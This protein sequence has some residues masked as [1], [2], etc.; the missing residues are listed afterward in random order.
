M[1]ASPVPTTSRHPRETDDV[2]VPATLRKSL[3]N[4]HIQLIAL[5]GAIGT[6]LFYGSSESI[7]LAGPSILLAYLV[8][9]LAIF[10]IVRA[11]SEMSVED[12]KAGAFSY[13]AT[14]YWSKRAGFVSGWNY[15]FN[16]ILVSMVE[17]SVVGSFVNYWFPN[18]PQWVSAA[19]FLVVIAA[20][21][22][23]G[24]SKFG[25]FEFW[26]A[27]IK[28]VAV[29][30]MIL[31]GLAVLVANLP[32]ASGI[33]AS[34]AN[35]FAI[36][37]GFF[38]HGLMQ[39][40][41]DGQWTGLLMALCVVM[42]SFGGTELIGITAGETENPRTTIPRATNGI[43]WRILVFYIGALGVIMAVVPWNTIDGKSS[44]FVQIFDS[45]GV[46]AAAGILNF[47]CL[48]AVMSVYNSGL[49]ANSRMLYSLAKQG[50][51]PAYLGK[52]NSRGVP[53]AGVITSAIITALAVV[54]V[55]LWPEFAFNYLMSIATIAGVINWSMIMITEVHFRKV[56]AAGDGPAELAGLQGK[57]AL[58]AIHFKLPFARVMPYI[59]LAFLALVVVLMCFSPS[60]RVAVVA[61]VIWLAILLAAYQI[62]QVRK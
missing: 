41:A 11:L 45:V 42:F 53:V 51:A 1:A 46:H 20:A 58:D 30:A 50:N 33:K 61:G 8:G 35:W 55:F 54:V 22:L 60:Y 49:Y 39:R 15:W 2:P 59:V 7:S 5:G 56:V 10:M 23:L 24:V 6:G 44:P 13:Y 16:Y 31:G 57:T 28:I 40:T 29:V 4:R 19:V 14:R 21:N 34:F 43:I 48:T 17:L 52:L 27:I 38:P 25:E 26:F 12:P 62:T 37:G 36:D 9:G 47:V 3:K 32:T 18:I